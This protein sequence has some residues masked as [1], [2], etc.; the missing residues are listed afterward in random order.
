MIIQ[1]AVRVI[2][3]RP[4]VENA[5]SRINDSGKTREGEQPEIAAVLE[6]G[7]FERFVY[8]TSVLECYSYQDCSI[9]LG[10]PQRDVIAA[11]IRALQQIGSVM[12]LHIKERVNVGS[13]KPALPSN[14]RSVLE[15][16]LHV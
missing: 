8:V 1:N 11:R 5:P 6:L 12:D 3:L 14:C 15:D 13:W 7:P 16:L 4:M 10:C 9:L 2:N